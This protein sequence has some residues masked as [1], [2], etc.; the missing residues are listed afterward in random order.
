MAAADGA[1]AVVRHGTADFCAVKSEDAMLPTRSL[2]AV[3]FSTRIRITQDHGPWKD[4]DPDPRGGDQKCL[5]NPHA[6]FGMT[7]ALALTVA[8]LYNNYTIPLASESSLPVFTKSICVDP[9]R[10]LKSKWL[11]LLA[12]SHSSAKK[13][14]YLAE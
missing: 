5:H 13:I 14:L 10:N 11:N 8:E 3:L 2:T 12:S 7:G 1:R 6:V 9:G 4:H